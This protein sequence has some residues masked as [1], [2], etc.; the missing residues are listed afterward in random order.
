[1]PGGGALLKMAVLI[2]ESSHGPW[3]ASHSLSLIHYSPTLG[4]TWL[5]RLSLSL[6]PCTKINTSLLVGPGLLEMEF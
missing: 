6:A 3:P 1:M 5:V 2:A 4:G